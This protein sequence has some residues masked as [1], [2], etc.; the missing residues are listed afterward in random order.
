MLLPIRLLLTLISLP[1]RLFLKL[2]LRFILEVKLIAIG[3]VAGLAAAYGF[4]LRDAFRTWGL[5]PGDK[6]RQMPGDDAVPD[7][8]IVDTRSLSIDAPPAAVWPWLVQLGYGRGGW[9][10]FA[11]MDSTGTPSGTAADCILDEFQ[12]LA[13]DD[14]V[15]TH[16]GGGFVVRALEPAESL[17]L[18]L[19]SAMVV[20]QMTAAA[21]ASDTIDVSA[22]SGPFGRGF[23]EDM[24]DFRLSW[25]VMLE[26]DG[27]DG[28]RLVSRYR[29]KVDLRGA[30]K[31]VGFRVIRYGL[32]ATIRRLMLGVKERVEGA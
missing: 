2:P 27:T 3:F 7:A 31:Q 25:S 18:Y 23:G 5:V 14:I 19:D 17:V 12:D 6:Q 11:R 13:V 26:P 16:A 9:Y 24:P 28:T 22:S 32:F 4:H 15:P 1:F 8:G 29:V 30:K 20:E 10:G 21:G